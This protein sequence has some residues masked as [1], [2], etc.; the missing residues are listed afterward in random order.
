MPQAVADRSFG[1]ID[2]FNLYFYSDSTV[3]EEVLGAKLKCYDMFKIKLKSRL[4]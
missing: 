4:N 2:W 3:L 1:Q